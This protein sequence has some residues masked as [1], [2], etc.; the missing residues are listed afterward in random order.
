MPVTHIDQSLDGVVSNNISEDSEQR[1][2]QLIK[3]G[4]VIPLKLAVRELLMVMD[5]T[6]GADKLE[7]PT[8]SG[9]V[10]LDRWRFERLRNSYRMAVI[11]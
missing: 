2:L 3:Q 1:R 8:T 11:R 6:L 10:Y 9:G 7:R 5:E 4:E